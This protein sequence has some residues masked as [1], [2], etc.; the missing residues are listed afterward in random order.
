MNEDIIIPQDFQ[1]GG[2]EN[3]QLKTIKFK[4]PIMPIGRG[5]C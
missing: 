4:Y 3:E 5:K 1:R 2:P